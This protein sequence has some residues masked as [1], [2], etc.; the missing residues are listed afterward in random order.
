MAAFGA[1]GGL[2]L[3]GFPGWVLARA[4]AGDTAV[5]FGLP[6]PRLLV[7]VLV[8]VSPEHSRAAARPVAPHG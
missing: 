8:G 4:S 6:P 1:A 2:L 5:A 3:G 7:V